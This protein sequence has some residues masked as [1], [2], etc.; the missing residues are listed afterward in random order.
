[1]TSTNSG[2]CL[3]QESTSA[4]DLSSKLDHEKPREKMAARNPGY[5]KKRL[6]PRISRG[7]FFSRFRTYTVSLDELSERWTTGS[8]HRNRQINQLRI[9]T[10]IM[11]RITEGS[12]FG[13]Q[14]IAVWAGMATINTHVYTNKFY[15]N[16]EAEICECF[17]N[18]VEA[19]I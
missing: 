4:F 16:I 12:V 17:K 19:K 10:R 14:N 15:K 8:V 18:K 1:M 5:E 13:L 7:H 2:T 3:P 9:S 6:V 11:K